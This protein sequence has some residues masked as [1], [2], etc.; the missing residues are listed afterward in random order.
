MAILVFFNYLQKNPKMGV[1]QSSE[2]PCTYRANK[3]Q[4]TIL[5]CESSNV[6]VKKS[7]F[8]QTSYI[9]QM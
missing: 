2:W 4:L 6:F 3:V 9:C 7:K 5:S 1:G 8:W